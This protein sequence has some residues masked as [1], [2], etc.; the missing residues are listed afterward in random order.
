MSKIL[1]KSISIKLFMGLFAC[2]PMVQAEPK[3]LIRLGHTSEEVTLNNLMS[4]APQ[5][6]T[7]TEQ[8]CIRIGTGRS[9][10]YRCQITFE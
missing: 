1:W 7:I 5:G 6:A 2:V 4:K 9:Y 8:S 10:R 3:T